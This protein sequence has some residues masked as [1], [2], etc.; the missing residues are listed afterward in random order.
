[1]T[2]KRIPKWES[3][4]WSYIS[5]GDGA[6]CPFYNDCGI[7]LRGKW[8]PDDNRENLNRVLDYE[9]SEPDFYD[10]TGCGGCGGIFK[11]VE[12]LAQKYLEMGKIHSPPVPTALIALCD[13]RHAVE[14]RE[15]SLKA[16]H[17]AIWWLGDR[18]VI[19]LNSNESTSKKRFSLF[20]EA[21][22]IL[23]HC[24]ASPAFSS[25]ETLQ[26]GSFNE[27]LAE[28]FALYISMPR[29]W[30]REK[31]AEVHDL[32]KI[33]EIFDVPE[34]VMCLRLRLLGLI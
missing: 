1:M 20:H 30:V 13:K 27:L 34:P 24:K 25:R 19:Q 12:M 10:S 32:D 23:A 5:S 33:A 17:G 18:W 16:Y 9:Q 11:M 8:C 7:R 3:E 26:Q 2:R 31:W 22:H 4:L 21:F 6:H 29:E 28:Y 15:V 14:V